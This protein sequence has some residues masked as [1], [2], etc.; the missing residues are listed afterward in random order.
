MQA[1][2]ATVIAGCSEQFEVEEPPL[3]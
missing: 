1:K 2:R 3:T